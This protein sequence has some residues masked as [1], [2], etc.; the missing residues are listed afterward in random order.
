MLT[1]PKFHTCED[2]SATFKSNASLENHL[3]NKHPDFEASIKKEIHECTKCN[4][5]T[6]RRSTLTRHMLK[7]S[8]GASISSICGYCNASFKYKDTLDTH[9]IK[10]HPDFIE[11]VKRKIYECSCCALKTLNRR[12]FEQHMQ[13]HS[14][15]RFITCR[16]CYIEYKT[17]RAFDEHIVKRHSQFLAS[18]SCEILSCTY[19]SYQTTIKLNLRHLMFTC[20]RDVTKC[21]KT[22]QR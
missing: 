12:A 20:V 17:Q 7:H 9:I 21:S 8:S 4:Y 15:D 18:V 10:N 6:T 22:N 3:L 14:T 5:K 1:H 13:T 16:H 2:C 19:C 11:S